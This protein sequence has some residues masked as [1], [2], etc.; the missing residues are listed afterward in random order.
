MQKQIKDLVPSELV[1]LDTGIERVKRVISDTPN[2]PEW[3]I[4]WAGLTS[5][6][7]ARVDF[8]PTE[9]VTVSTEDGKSDYR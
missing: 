4:Q 9:W 5:N 7:I 1:K 2:S 3:R 8:L 6:L